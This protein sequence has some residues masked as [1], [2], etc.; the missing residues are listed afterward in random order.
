MRRVVT[1]TGLVID[2]APSSEV[3]A[4]DYL[5]S[6]GTGVGLQR[7]TDFEPYVTRDAEVYRTL[8]GTWI[9]VF[10]PGI[11]RIA[12][13]TVR[14]AFQAAEAALRAMDAVDRLKGVG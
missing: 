8:G 4:P 12:T 3:G 6:L 5:L 7:H 13:G 14:E 2:N 11:R 10:P 9:A 1:K